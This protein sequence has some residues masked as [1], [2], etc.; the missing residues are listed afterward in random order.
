MF[1]LLGGE[2][3]LCAVLSYTRFAKLRRPHLLEAER[4]QKTK[5]V[6]VKLSSTH[7]A[8]PRRRTTRH[9]KVGF[10]RFEHLFDTTGPTYWLAT[11]MFDVDAENISI[12]FPAAWK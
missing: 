6:T 2:G 12:R 3:P 8:S 10:R 7:P 5:L 4:K 9:E 11:W 1:T